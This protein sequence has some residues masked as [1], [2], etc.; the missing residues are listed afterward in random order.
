MMA[1]AEKQ[2]RRSSLGLHKHPLLSAGVVSTV[3][4]AKLTASK[5]SGRR[6]DRGE[7]K[8]ERGIKK[9]Y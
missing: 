1:L 3:T 2:G 4:G 7:R 5:E 6:K 9:S 8:D